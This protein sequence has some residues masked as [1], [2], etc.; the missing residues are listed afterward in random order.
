M[1][2]VGHNDEMIHCNRAVQEAV[3]DKIAGPK[4]LEEIEGGHFG[5]LWSPGPLFDQ[6]SARQVTFL[7]ETISV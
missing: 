1:M 4:T 2:M 6:A 7:R 5:L 3:F